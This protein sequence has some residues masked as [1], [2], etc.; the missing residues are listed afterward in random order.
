MPVADELL[1]I[2]PPQDTHKVIRL[3]VSKKLSLLHF[4]LNVKPLAS[5]IFGALNLGSVA[6]L[7]LEDAHHLGVHESSKLHLQI[8]VYHEALPPQPPPLQLALVQKPLLLIN[9]NLTSFLKIKNLKKIISY[10]EH[11]IPC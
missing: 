5:P 8:V 7:Q 1:G 4:F 3:F 10:L 2:P 11:V 9:L 6:A